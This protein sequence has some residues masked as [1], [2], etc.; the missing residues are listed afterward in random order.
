MIQIKNSAEIEGMRKACRVAADVLDEMIPAVAPGISPWELDQL[1]KQ[2]IEKHGATSACYRYRSGRLVF[3]AYTC[4]SV[5]EEIVHGI[6]RP[7][8]RLHIGDIVSLDISVV[9]EGWVGDNARTVAVG[10]LQDKVER[11]V[12][13]TREAFYKG[14]EWARKGNHV[15]DISYAVQRHAEAAGFGIVR[16]F[17]GH[18][19]GRGMHEEP[20]I[21]NYGYRGRGPRL[22][23]GMTICIEPMVTLGSPSI[24]IGEDGWVALTRDGK[25]A[26]HHENTVLVT[27][28]EPEILT[29]PSSGRMND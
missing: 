21:P 8:K 27:D 24:S 10:P 13:V 23:P 17:V 19:V 20:Q 15:G 16:E 29:V 22:A 12:T 6:G 7:E 11:L 14:M 18:G 25:P 1:G 4:L 9:F 3:P 5:N 26:S 28:G 2:L